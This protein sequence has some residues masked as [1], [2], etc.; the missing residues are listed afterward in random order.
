MRPSLTRSSPGAKDVE[1][2]FQMCPLVKNQSW[3]ESVDIVSIESLMEIT[4]IYI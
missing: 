2:A 4:N 3:V 1:D